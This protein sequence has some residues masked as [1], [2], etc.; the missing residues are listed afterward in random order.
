VLSYSSDYSRLIWHPGAHCSFHTDSIHRT[1]RLS[2]NR[3]SRLLPSCS[4]QVCRSL[5]SAIPD[6]S[7][8]IRKRLDRLDQLRSRKVRE[9]SRESGFHEAKSVSKIYFITEILAKFSS[10]AIFTGLAKAFRRRAQSEPKPASIIPYLGLMIHLHIPK[11][12][13]RT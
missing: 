12:S 5:K 13:L 10:L 6:H 1:F 3:C 8:F 7:H 4:R 9:T 2:R 11:A